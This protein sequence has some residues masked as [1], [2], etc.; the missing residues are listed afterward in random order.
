MLKKEVIGLSSI[1]MIFPIILLC[2]CIN[3]DNLFW[4]SISPNTVHESSDLLVIENIKVVPEKVYTGMDFTVYFTVK[5]IGDP[6]TSEEVTYDVSLY[7]FGVC[8]ALS[9]TQWSNEKI[10]PGEIKDYSVTF[11]APSSGEIGN[12][13][14]HCPIRF[15]IM[16]KNVKARTQVEAYVMSEERMKMLQRTG[17]F[18]SYVPTQRTGIGPVK[19]YFEFAQDQP[20]IAGKNVVFFVYARNEGDGNVDG[21][22]ISVNV[23]VAG[24]TS[25]CSAELHFIGDETNKIKCTWKPTINGDEK[26]FY[27]IAEAEYA[28]SFEKT[29]EVT[30]Y[31]LP[32]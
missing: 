16:Y 3:Q 29:E 2:G 19:I 18:Q 14:A 20:F 1:A 10:Q 24:G 8:S 26:M 31:P 22:K 13:E 32:E 21:G 15:K 25:I 7:D 17:K 6:R 30:V 12:L 23:K 9:Q 4:N 11:K 5:H 28:Y 27:L